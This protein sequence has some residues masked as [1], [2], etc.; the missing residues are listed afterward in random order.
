MP[1]EEQ[2]KILENLKKHAKNEY[3]NEVISKLKNKIENFKD[4]SLKA[5]KTEK[6]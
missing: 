1:K 2:S 6:N 5:Y 3:S 4:K